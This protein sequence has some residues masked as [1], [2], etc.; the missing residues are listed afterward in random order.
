MICDTEKSSK[1]ANVNP[2]LSVITLNI[3]KCKYK[4]KYKHPIKR[5]K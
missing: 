2:Y 3:S 1:E 4:Y 5:L